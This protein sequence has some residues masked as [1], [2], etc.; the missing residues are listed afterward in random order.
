VQ[1][2]NVKFTSLI[3]FGECWHNNHHA[4]P[5]S[6]NLGLERGQ[7]DLGWYVLKFFERLGLVRHL[8][9]PETLKE[10]KILRRLEK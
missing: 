7:I 3:T 6:A 8:Q 9:T 10:R 5:G 2:F 1:G 4:F